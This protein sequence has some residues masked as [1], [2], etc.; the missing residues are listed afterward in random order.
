MHLAAG[1]GA[2]VLGA[3]ALARGPRRS[4]NRLFAA[5]CG[6]LATWGI[7]VA[8]GQAGGQPSGHWYLVY[9]LGSCSAAP[10][11]LHFVI[12][13]LRL[14]GIP[15]RVLLPLGYAVAA[16]L[17]GS[18]WTSW[19]D[20]QPAW[21][22]VAIVVLGAVHLVALLLLA[23]HF[24]SLPPGQERAAFRLFLGGAA[25]AAGAGLSDL[26]PRQPSG[27]PRVGPVGVLI[28][29]VI[30]CSIVVRHRFLD[31]H[32]FLA[33]ALAV[34]LGAAVATVVIYSM[35]EI[36]GGSVLL[37]FI[38]MAV[39]IALSGPVG[40][41]LLS[42][43]RGVLRQGETVSRALAGLSGDLSG[44]TS[45][46]Q[47]WSAIERQVRLLAGDVTV[48][49]H[50]REK[51]GEPFAVS[52]HGGRSTAPGAVEPESA[53]AQFLEAERAPL[54]R[55]ILAD[56]AW[57]GPCGRGLLA[58]AA[59]EQMNSLGAELTAPLH[60]GGRLIGW[61]SLGGGLPESY[62]TAET[63]TALL[64]VA[65]QAVASLERAR[66]VE[67]AKRREA[68]A[69][70]GEMAAGLAHEIRNPLSAI[71]GAAEVLAI[72]KDGERAREMLDVIQVESDRLGRVVGEF[73]EYAR[74]APP[75]REPVDLGRLLSAV[76]VSAQAAGL[77][78]RTEL[79][80][81][82]GTPPVLADPDQLHR[83]FQNIVRNA[84]EAA[85]AGGSL[86][87]DVAPCGAGKVSV[88]FEDNGPGIPDEDLARLFQPF[89]TTKP[90]G[91]GLGLALVHRV[92]DA[93]G[94][95]IHVEGRPGRGAVFTV[96]LPSSGGPS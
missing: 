55:R 66:A 76:L 39:I 74:P 51:R 85:G 53:F 96:M 94:G 9:L 77:G 18:A 57:E 17:Y 34:L 25:V 43:A 50:A 31:V 36:A 40:R 79:R 89:H 54:T 30:V 16:A 8:T 81:A 69:A 91:T 42:G 15:R 64:A 23:R 45:P 48:T 61:V 5:L 67:I 11:G 70:V 13:L 73:L 80:T 35:F 71:R 24:L 72:Q 68:L 78:L 28:L 59:L 3:G 63:S 44:A 4:R 37:S 38:A 88:R 32:H 58:S 22:I 20:S 7:G 47:I 56:E 46:P 62:L 10:L 21:N 52:Y 84:S 83:S 92:V 86:L 87:I 60:S 14:N 95:E 33:R 65:N 82:E 41:G 26:I 27:L 2:L 12:S 6:A 75:R 29:L 19:H 93:H 49:V 90:G 1:V